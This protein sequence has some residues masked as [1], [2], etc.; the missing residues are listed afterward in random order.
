MR[1]NFLIVGAQK[2]ASTYLQS[3]LTQHPNV[4]VCDNEIAIFEDP[5]YAHFSEQAIDRLFVGRSEARLGIKRPSYIGRPE[6]PERI[7]S[8]VPEAKLIA[9]LRNPIDRAL[10]GYFYYMAGSYIP[11]VDAETGMRNLLEGRYT[12]SYQRSEEILEFGKYYKYISMYKPYIDSGRMLLI[13][14]EDL[15]DH[16]DE[17]FRQVFEFLDVDPEFRPLEKKATRQPGQYNLVSQRIM[18]AAGK[19]SYR[20]DESNTRA[21]PRPSALLR[22]CGKSI[23]FTTNAVS[24]YLLENRKPELSNSCLGSLYGYYEDDVRRLEDL[25]GWDLS[26]WKGHAKIVSSVGKT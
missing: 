9:V 11:L 26:S 6:V 2:S 18:R 20:K 24:E 7:H 23:L 15:L 16:P 25:T 19:I 14:Q 10:S 21:H 22:F 12:E 17:N 3:C 1:L 5:D 8:A 13:R 4:Y